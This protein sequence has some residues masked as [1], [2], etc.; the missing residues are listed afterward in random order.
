MT[1]YTLI[2]IYLLS[3]L[4]VLRRS[5]HNVMHI[6]ALHAR[7]G[8]TAAFS[9]AVQVYYS[10]ADHNSSASG[11]LL[12]GANL[13]ARGYE[14]RNGGSSWIG[15]SHG[16]GSQAAFFCPNPWILL[17]VMTVLFPSVDTAVF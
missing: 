1:P 12:I 14:R 17:P 7:Q 5:E 16:L 4:P 9:Y 15:P 11:I 3:T 6:P 10:H 2:I 13:D 8:A